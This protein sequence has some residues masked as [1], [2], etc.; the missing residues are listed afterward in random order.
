MAILDRFSLKGKSAVISGGAGIYGRQIMRAIAEAGART[1]VASRDVV[2]LDAEAALLRNEGLDVTALSLD[3]EKEESI[4]AL[5]DEVTRVAGR[6]DILVNNAVLRTMKSWQDSSDAFAR[7]MAVNAT[8][9]FLIT[10]AFC[11]H[12][13][14]KGGGSVINIG[15]IQGMV[16][17]DFSLYEGLGLSTVPDY[18]FHKGGMIQLTRFAAS[19]YGP[20]NVRVNCL[21]P[22]G[23]LYGQPEEFVRRYNQRTF[24]GR[25]AGES[26]LGGAIVFLACDAS[27]YITGANIPVDGGYTAK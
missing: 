2:K 6:V 8:G 15:S 10:R 7:S 17:P 5:R 26:D 9:I 13:A 16:G 12:M 22:G 14:E 19:V 25:M 27:A 1:F 11:D 23:F 24:L 18:F 21:S 3:Q 20:K 4:L